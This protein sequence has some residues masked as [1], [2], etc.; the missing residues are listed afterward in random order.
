MKGSTNERQ[1]LE[2]G[3]LLLLVVAAT[4]A[5]AFLIGPF[6]GA[7]LWGIIAAILFAPL[8][9][10]LLRAIPG[11]RNLAALVT[12]FVIV[13]V[14]IIPALLL[15]AA[16]T[17]EASAIYVKLQSGDI[18]IGR[19]FIAAERHLPG[20]VQRWLA[21]L[22]LTNMDT[23]KARVTPGIAS[24]LQAVATKAFNVGQSALGFFLSLGAMLYLTF[25]LLRDGNSIIRKIEHCMPIA[26]DQRRI[27][28]ARFVTVV[29]ATIKGSV[30]V[31][32]L[33]GAIGGVVFWSLGIDGALL[34]SVAMGI[35]SLLPAVGT[36]LIWVP[37]TLYLFAS[38]Q[39]WQAV[40]LSLCGFFI[41]GSVDN[42]VRPILIGH[43]TR[44]PDYVVLIATLGGFELM[45]ANG[46]VIGPV[47]AALF[48]TVWQIFADVP[49]SVAD[50]ESV[51]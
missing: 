14:V 31:A 9:K 2:H 25:F 29:R 15:G 46:F 38:G 28:V 50:A 26:T 1:T 36:G 35:F 8:H 13:A 6:I 27:L 45:G 43:D 44:M 11:K 41:I 16:L 39:I 30:I 37:V 23:L 7:I 49:S 5:F 47:I 3:F 12:L 48:I 32:L 18:D 21:E 22:G 20:V 33:Q 4:V 19:M 17:S 10:R 40:K 34:W 42:I 24:S 51:T